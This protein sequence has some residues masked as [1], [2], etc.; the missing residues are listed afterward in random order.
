MKSFYSYISDAWSSPREGVVGALRQDRLRSWR[1]EMTVQRIDKPT[2]LDRARAP[3]K[4]SGQGIAVARSKFAGRLLQVQV[5]QEQEDQAHGHGKDHH[6]QI[7]PA[8]S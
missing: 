5:H 6:G 1:R 3:S 7:H 8:H 2:R 4:A